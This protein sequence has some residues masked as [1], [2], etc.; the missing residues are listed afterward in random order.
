MQSA[1]GPVSCQVA[2]SRGHPAVS[3]RRAGQW[4]HIQTFDADRRSVSGGADRKESRSR[5]R[6]SAPSPR[7]RAHRVHRRGVR[8]RLRDPR[9]GRHFVARLQET[10]AR[11]AIELSVEASVSGARPGSRTDRTGRPLRDGHGRGHRTSYFDVW[12][13]DCCVRVQRGIEAAA[14]SRFVDT[15]WGTRCCRA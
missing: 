2:I 6:E 14:K 8:R 13:L 3:R 11:V 1:I 4:R 10:R 15:G 7:A 12:G 5:R 9:R